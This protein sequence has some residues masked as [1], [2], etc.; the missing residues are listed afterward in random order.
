MKK[1]MPRKNQ[2]N[3]SFIEDVTIEN[4]HFFDHVSLGTNHHI[5]FSSKKNIT[6]F[7]INYIKIHSL[8]NDFLNK[9]TYHNRM[10]YD[11][12]FFLLLW[13]SGLICRFASLTL[14]V[15]ELVCIV[16]YHFFCLFAV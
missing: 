6:F 16:V 13:S 7:I 15:P 10:F 14:V 4:K 12:T 11:C 5:E 1:C 2:N 3:V 9:E 8:R